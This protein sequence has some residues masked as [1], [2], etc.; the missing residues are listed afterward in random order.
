MATKGRASAPT[1]SA[2]LPFASTPAHQ[3]LYYCSAL[4]L[5]MVPEPGL[6]LGLPCGKGILSTLEKGGESISI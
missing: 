4:T 1:A 5:V 2:A 3:L 6:E